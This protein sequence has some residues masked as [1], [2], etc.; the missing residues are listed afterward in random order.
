MMFRV[1][2]AFFV[3]ASFV[4]LGLLLL[5]PVLPAVSSLSLTEDRW[6]LEPLYVP[7]VR[8]QLAVVSA[9][10]LWGSGPAL[11]PTAVI[12][13]A[14]LSPPDWRI[15]GVYVV[16][17]RPVAMISTPGKPDQAL[18]LGDTLPGGARI[19]AIFPDRIAIALNGRRLYLSTY[20]E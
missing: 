20:Q 3:F 15:A 16:A 5:P 1:L 9:V 11:P 2:G 6:K 19:L 8:A 13:E 10:R 12:E 18:K 14:A 17:D 7:D 4:L